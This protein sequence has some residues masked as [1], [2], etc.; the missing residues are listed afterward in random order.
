[1]HAPFPFLVVAATLGAGCAPSV[2]T[3]PTEE[4]VQDLEHV[5]PPIYQLLY[6]APVLPETQSALQRVR[7]LIWLIQLDLNS[8]Q[9]HALED[10]RA[11]VVQRQQALQDAEQ[12]AAQQQEA[13]ERAVYDALF[14]A[15][16]SGQSLDDPALQPS[17]AAL[18]ELRTNGDDSERLRRRLEALRATMEAMSIFVRSLS[19]TQ[20]NMVAD[21]LFFLRNR[22]DP[23]GNPGDFKSIVGSLYDPGQYAVLTRGTGEEALKPLN[24]G[25]LWSDEPELTGRALH[26]AQREVILFFALQEPGMEE[27]IQAALALREQQISP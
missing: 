14:T 1:M 3:L 7:M 24:I 16:R 15:L 23:V 11:G 21:A 19:Q 6:D 5:A 20:E 10:L 17:I 4:S 2:A 25:G 9:L 26:S 18:T 8:A 27:A 12:Q 22:L 13:Q